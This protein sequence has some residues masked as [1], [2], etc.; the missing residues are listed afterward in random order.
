MSFLSS[1]SSKQKN[2]KMKKMKCY[3]SFS[4]NHLQSS[5]L[6][7]EN[8]RKKKRNEPKATLVLE[9]SGMNS[10]EFISILYKPIFAQNPLHFYYLHFESKENSF[11]PIEV[12]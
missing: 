5:T 6:D 7:G 3:T 12:K 9:M 1:S 11:Y 8:G 10:F 4:R 2:E